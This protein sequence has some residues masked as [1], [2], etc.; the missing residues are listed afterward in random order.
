MINIYDI[1]TSLIAFI[2]L[3]TVFIVQVIIIKKRRE[4][5]K[6]AKNKWKTRNK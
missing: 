6:N 1:S 3:L 4:V 5:I 2:I